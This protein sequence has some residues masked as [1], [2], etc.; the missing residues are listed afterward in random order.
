MKYQHPRTDPFTINVIAPVGGGQAVA[1]LN[2]SVDA[3]GTNVFSSTNL[4]TIRDGL[5]QLC[6]Q[7]YHSLGSNVVWQLGVYTIDGTLVR[8]LTPTVT[9]AVGSATASGD[10]LTCDLTTLMNGVYDLQLTVSGGYTTASSS[11][12]FRL[13]SNLKV[14]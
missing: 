12:E 7:A 4:V 5:M 8:N 9:S 10:L 3:T 1:S 11:I 14:G 13:E 6:G 2:Y